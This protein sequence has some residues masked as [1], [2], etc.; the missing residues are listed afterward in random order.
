M[1]Q[2]DNPLEVTTES[3]DEDVNMSYDELS[4]FCQLLVEKYDM[5]KKNK[6]NDSISHHA[7]HAT[8][9]DS[10]INVLKNRISCLSS[11]LSS[12]AFNHK[13]LETLFSKKQVPNIH[14][15]YHHAF[16]YVARSHT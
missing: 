2:G 11:T 1:V 15:H 10:E 3:E 16:A 7:L 14:A 6:K 8:T 9:N 4:T 12:C 13:K 5:L